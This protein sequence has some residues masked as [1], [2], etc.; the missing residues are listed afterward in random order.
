MLF[1][2]CPIADAQQPKKVYRIGYLSSRLG[3]EAREE[4]FL[5]GLRESGLRCK[6]RN[7]IIEWRFTKGEGN[8]RCH[9]RG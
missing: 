4:A 8:L 9:V 5:K 3:I 6:D 2:F 7:I 1:A